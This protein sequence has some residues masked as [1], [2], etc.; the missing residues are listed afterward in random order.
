M[1]RAKAGREYGTTE[2][3]GSDAAQILPRLDLATFRRDYLRDAF[4]KGLL[5]PTSEG[6]S[7]T[8][9]PLLRETDAILCNIAFQ[10]REKEGGHNTSIDQKPRD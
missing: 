8:L 1:Y 9:D 5:P 2:D 4:E 6:D 10:R 7:T 3:G